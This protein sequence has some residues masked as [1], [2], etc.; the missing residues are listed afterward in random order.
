MTA[1]VSASVASPYYPFPFFRSPQETDFRL[2]EKFS[3]LL[4][5]SAFLNITGADETQQRTS[6]PF[7][8]VQDCSDG[9]SSQ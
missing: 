7:L 4:R 3:L 5:F 2:E 9:E 6:F 1:L 8:S